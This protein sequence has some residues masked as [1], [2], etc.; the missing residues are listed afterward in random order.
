MSHDSGRLINPTIVEGQIQ[1]AVALGLGSALL[2][3]VRYDAQGQPLAGSYMD[4]A[5]PRADDFPAFVID[6]LETPSP[7][8]PLGVKGAGEA[9]VIPGAA[10][11][12][13]AIEDAESAT[14]AGLAQVPVHPPRSGSGRP[15]GV[16]GWLAL[17]GR[18]LAPLARPPCLRA[19]GHHPELGRGRRE[20][21]R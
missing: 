7:L 13:S 10:V 17:P 18:Q 6:H 14:P 19:L 11:F 9:G 20:K 2:E 5:M 15:R 8:N 16:R 4:Y 3:E 21:K 1:G 12:A